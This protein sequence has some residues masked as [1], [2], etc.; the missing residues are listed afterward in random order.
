MGGLDG[1]VRWLGWQ[2]GWMSELGEWVGWMD[3]IGRVGIKFGSIL[4]VGFRNC[5][6]PEKRREVQR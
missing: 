4:M 3:W 5:E 2:V 1:W 6:V